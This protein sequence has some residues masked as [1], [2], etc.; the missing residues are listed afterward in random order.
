MSTVEHPAGDHVDRQARRDC[1]PADGLRET[2]VERQ[3]RQLW[4]LLQSLTGRLGES[5]LK[6]LVG[7]TVS[8]VERHCIEAALA[9]TGGNRSAAA[10]VLGLSRQSLYIKL[11]R[12]R[13]GGD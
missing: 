5:T 13:I 2:D 1:H 9:M 4:Q 3:Q 12:Y 8:T 7:E 6:M 10:K 11:A